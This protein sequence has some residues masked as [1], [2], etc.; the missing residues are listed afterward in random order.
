[1]ADTTRPHRF[2]EFITVYKYYYIIT[3]YL[4]TLAPRTTKKIQEEY[5]RKKSRKQDY[6]YMHVQYQKLLMFTVV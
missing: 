6:H 3:L 4:T 1:M 5:K 2:S